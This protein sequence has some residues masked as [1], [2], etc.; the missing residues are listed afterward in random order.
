MWVQK[1]R[2]NWLRV[3]DKNSCFFHKV[4]KVRESRNNLANLIF[5]GVCISNPKAIKLAIFNHFQSFFK[6]SERWEAKLKC[7]S[8]V[9]SLDK[10]MLE[11]S[12]TEAEI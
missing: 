8:R 9:S 1:S 7:D 11:E 3:G 10:A 5:D 2:L 12:F 4:C 6:R